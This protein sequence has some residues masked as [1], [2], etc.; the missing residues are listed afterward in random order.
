MPLAN[1]SSSEKNA[2]SSETQKLPLML[3]LFFLGLLSVKSSLVFSGTSVF[4]PTR[5]K[6]GD[7]T[8]SVVSLY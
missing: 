1:L 3:V 7:L 6:H 5:F 2:V 8:L 4:F